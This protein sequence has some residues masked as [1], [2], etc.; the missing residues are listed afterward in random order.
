MEGR[1]EI[2]ALLSMRGHTEERQTNVCVPNFSIME[3]IGIDNASFL[4]KLMRDF[5]YIYFQ[6][7]PYNLSKG[8]KVITSNI[9][10]GS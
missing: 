6:C 4:L 2:N 9:L 3:M 10:Q 8:C 7:A 5:A 1:L